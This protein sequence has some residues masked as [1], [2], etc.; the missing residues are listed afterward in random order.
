MRNGTAVKIA[1]CMVRVASSVD[2]GLNNAIL[3]SPHIEIL[4]Q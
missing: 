2:D 1:E 4:F 3:I